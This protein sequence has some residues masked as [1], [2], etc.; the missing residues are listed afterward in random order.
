MYSR[1]RSTGAVQ[2][3]PARNLRNVPR[4]LPRRLWPTEAQELLLRAALAPD[5]PEGPARAAWADFRSGFDVDH[6]EDGSY[7]LMPLLYRRLEAWEPNDPLVLRLKGI[8]RHTWYRGNVLL[9]RLREVLE[10]TRTAGLDVLVTGGARL[11]VDV[12]E[13]PG[14]RPATRIDLVVRHDELERLATALGGAGW[15]AAEGTPRR[16]LPRTTW[17]LREG[18]PAVVLQTRLL[19]HRDRADE[20]EPWSAST[21]VTFRDVSLPVPSATDELL[22]ICLGEERQ[23]FWIRLQWLA[24]VKLLLDRPSPRLDWERAIA[25]ASAHEA[26]LQLRDALTYAHR[27]AGAAIPPEA[28]SRLEEARAPRRERLHYHLSRIDRS[29]IPPV[30]RRAVRRV[31]S[32]D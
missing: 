5:A 10:C 15:T 6:M 9:D 22:R 32:H 2:R 7:N 3:L 20:H 11:L 28:L 1:P 19:P 4:G 8:Y 24:D 31:L 17:L 14:L 27:V 25:D 16:R 13:D 29:R 30:A 12:Y 18:D 23:L 21:E 26:T